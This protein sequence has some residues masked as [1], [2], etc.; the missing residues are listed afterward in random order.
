MRNPADPDVARVSKIVRSTMT[1]LHAEMMRSISHYRAQQQGSAPQRV[2]LCGGSA[3][4]PYM[5]EF[6]HEK[7]QLPIEFFNPLRNV[8]VAN[9]VGCDEVAHSAHLARRTGRAGV[10]AAPATCPMELNLRPASVVDGAPRLSG[11]V[12]SSSSRRPVSCSVC[13][14]GAFYFMRAARHRARLREQLQVESRRMRGIA[15]ADGQVAETGDCARQPA[16]RLSTRSTI[17]A[18]GSRS[19]KT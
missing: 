12:R 4:T 18:S 3:S 13:S 2:F 7:L 9:S 19:S 8:A 15:N 16:R 6:F 1:R 5:R 14:A 17:A 11:A 10:C